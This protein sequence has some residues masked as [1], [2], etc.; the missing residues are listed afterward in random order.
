MTQ[1][2]GSTSARLVAIRLKSPNKYIFRALVSIASAVLLIRLMGMVNQVIVTGRFGAGAQMDAYFVAVSLP[3]LLSDMIKSSIE[4]SVVP[5]YARLRTRGGREEASKLFS[6]LL[7][8]LM[9][10]AIVF[11]LIF[12]LFRRQI[13][14]FSAPG[15]DV[16]RAGI[17]VNLIPIAL[18]ALMLML[19]IGFLECILNTEGHFG[20]PAYAGILVPLTTAIFVYL[21]G[22]SSFGVIMLLIGTV[23]GLCLQLCFFTMR[24]KRTKISYR[25]ATLDLRNPALKQIFLIAWPILFGSLISQ[26]SPLVDQIFASGL[27]TGNI[28]ALSYALKLISVPIGVIFASVGRAALPYFAR[29][30]E[31]NDLNALKETLRLY[32]WMVSIGTLVL[33]SFMIVLSH[34][35]VQ[36]LFQ[37]GTF[38]AAD[39]QRTSTILIGLSIGLTPMAFGFIVSKVFAALGKSRVLMLVT[40]FSVIA[41]AVFDYIFARLWQG[42]GIAVATSTVYFCTMIILVVT[43]ERVIGRIGLH[44]PPQ[45]VE[46]LIWKLGLGSYYAKWIAWRKNNIPVLSPAYLTSK[47]RGY[48]TKARGQIARLIIIV[49]VFVA[50]VAG[51]LYNSA[52]AVRIALGSLIIL[53]LLRFR[54]ALLLTWIMVI[55]FIGSSVEIFNG[56]NIDSGLTAP[57]LLLMFALPVKQAFKR[58]PALAF[59]LAFL[60][61]TFASIGFSSLGVGTFLVDW[62]ILLDY[63]A[64]GVLTISVVTTRRRLEILLDAFLLLSSGIAVYGLYGYITKHGGTPDPTGNLALFRTASIFGGVAT[65]FALFLSIVIPLS[66]YYTVSSRGFRRFIGSIQFLLFLVALLLTFTR[67]ALLIVPVTLI[68]MIF[69]LPS[70]K[71]KIAAFSGLAAL[72]ALGALAAAVANVPVLERFFSQD[73][74]S[75]NG[76]LSLW[77]TLLDRFDPA[78]VL[79]NGLD[80]SNILLTNLHSGISGVIA[81]APHNLF[82]GTLYDQ[83]II[84]LVL[85][86]LAFSSLGI[87]LIKGIRTARGDRRLLFVAASAILIN[88]LVQAFEA[89]DILLQSVGIYFWVAM[90]L[91]FALCWETQEKPLAGK[92][93]AMPLT[94]SVDEDGTVAEDDETTEPRL[95]VV[96]PVQRAKA[97]LISMRN[98]KR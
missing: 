82:I 40:T 87:H 44:R 81:S 9:M 6:T 29:Q 10:G 31:G 30:I 92:G 47:I 34:P 80:A 15:L 7:N 67:G 69:F 38:L 93:E 88:I 75:L 70:K 45:Q 86:V 33:T 79:G 85:L 21:G 64:I 53:A 16:N 54:Y 91:P 46:S 90:A 59:L 11:S 55:V 17:A 27:S 63:V 37:R 25:P 18:I 22:K 97:D 98:E 78:Q 66:L 50:G 57:T 51:T 4:T 8:L 28:S 49:T 19:V 39:T 12:F 58:L 36:I 14:F 89:A 94:S 20:W 62:T 48:T 41:N 83:G 23:V 72:V 95:K 35:I 3:F 71:M 96:R 24:M 52:Y 68:F 1:P 26:G 42:F 5:V 56:K 76:R 73:V 60:L 84:G 32:L 65:M 77:Q 2:L 74:T 43:L 13:V 61:W